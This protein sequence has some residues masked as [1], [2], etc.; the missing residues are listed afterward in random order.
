MRLQRHAGTEY[1]QGR[2]AG[3]YLS[4][5]LARRTLGDLPGAAA[6]IRRSVALLDALALRT[7]DLYILSASAHAALAGLAAM[8]GSGV[9]VADEAREAEKAVALLHE[10]IAMGYR[11]PCALRVEDALDPLHHRLDF[12]LLLMDLSFPAYPFVALR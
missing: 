5:G 6:D 10:A 7:A 4:R 9:A 12:G 8:H 1:M 3:D 2:L 11:D